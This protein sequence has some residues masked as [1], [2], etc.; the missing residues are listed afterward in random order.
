[1]GDMADYVR[2]RDMGEE[3]KEYWELQLQYKE[4]DQIE[5]DYMMGNLKWSTNYGESILVS[6][7]TEEH[8][9]NTIKFMKKKKSN[10]RREKWIE[11][12]YIELEKR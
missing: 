8:I 6:K 1:M 2:L 5:K 11:I 10:P 7:M 4:A 3:S 9:M 12:F